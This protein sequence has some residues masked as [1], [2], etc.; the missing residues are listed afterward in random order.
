MKTLHKL[1]V[2]G[3]PSHDGIWVL[4]PE[5][6]THHNVPEKNPIIVLDSKEHTEGENVIDY[7]I[8][9]SDVALHIVVNSKKG[10]LFGSIKKETNVQG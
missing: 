9:E 6:F 10:Q 4:F 2:R 1:F 3:F 5:N 8:N 7:F